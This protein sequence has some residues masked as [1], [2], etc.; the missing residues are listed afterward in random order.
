MREDSPADLRVRS[1][2][3]L[4]FILLAVGTGVGVYWPAPTPLDCPIGEIRFADPGAGPPVA[5]CGAGESTPA[6]AVLA[7]G[8]RLDLNSASE[9]DLTLIPG[10]G[11]SLAHAIVRARPFESWEQVDSVPGVGASK[12][13]IL[14]AYGDL[15][16]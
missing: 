1:L 7:V 9:N 4:V 2:A 13:E 8:G 11:P 10:I 5:T 14:Q 15:R 3:L 16:Q 12:M 6:G